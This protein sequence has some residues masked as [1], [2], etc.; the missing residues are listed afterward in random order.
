MNFLLRELKRKGTMRCN[1]IAVGSPDQA[2]L[3][4]ELAEEREVFF[5]GGEVRPGPYW[6]V[7]KQDAPALEQ[8]GYSRGRAD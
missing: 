7:H 4:A 1:C 2:L 6:V 5:M 3:V 8:A